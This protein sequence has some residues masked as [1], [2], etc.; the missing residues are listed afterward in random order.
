[1]LPHQGFL[2]HSSNKCKEELQTDFL[3]G[4]PGS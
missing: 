4:E 2:L 3:Q 1:M